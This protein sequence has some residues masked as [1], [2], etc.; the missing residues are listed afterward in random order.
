MPS[1]RKKPDVRAERRRVMAEQLAAGQLAIRPLT[2]DDLAR[3]E[4]ARARRDQV[5]RGVGVGEWR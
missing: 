2:P 4:R 5:A 1:L 3:L